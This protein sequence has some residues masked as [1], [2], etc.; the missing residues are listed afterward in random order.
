MSEETYIRRMPQKLTTHQITPV[1][2]ITGT[3]WLINMPNGDQVA[4][5]AKYDPVNELW[6]CYFSNKESIA[7]WNSAK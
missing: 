4:V 6:W 2:Q 3:N 1:K 7:T 5:N